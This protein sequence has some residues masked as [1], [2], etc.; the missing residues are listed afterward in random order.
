MTL[1]V[2]LAL[3]L[4]IA[5]ASA[6]FGVDSRDTRHREQMRGSWVGMT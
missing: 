3:L 4:G 6:R 1:I 5:L 2:G